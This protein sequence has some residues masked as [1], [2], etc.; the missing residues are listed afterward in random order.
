MGRTAQQ[1]EMDK[2]RC[3]NFANGAYGSQMPVNNSYNQYN[4]QGTTSNGTYYSGT[5]TQQPTQQQEVT[6]LA[7]STTNLFNAINKNRAFEACLN[8]MGWYTRD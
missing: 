2:A 7:N 4:F 6:N 3:M 5:A 1:F 8:N